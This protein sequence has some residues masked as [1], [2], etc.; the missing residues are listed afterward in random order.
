VSHQRD[1]AAPTA[2][3]PIR[4]VPVGIRRVALVLSLVRLVTPLAVIPFA[5]ALI[6]GDVPLLLL[7]RPARE[8]LLLGGGLSR[9]V[10]DPTVMALV[11]A[12]LP[13][14]TLGVWVFYIV[15]RAYGPQL[16]AG[17]GP[18]WLQR[19]IPQERLIQ[20]SRVLTRRG[21]A[22]AVVSR[23]AGFPPTLLAAAA[24]ASDVD[25]RRYLVADLFGMVLTFTTVVGIGFALGRAYERGGTWLTA[26]GIGLVVVLAITVSRWVQ[27][28][29][30]RPDL[31]ADPD[32]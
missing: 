3:D 20:S 25:S 7:L 23:L 2:D 1:V 18:A 32:A 13:L 16:R 12:Y 11:L 10:G 31:P 17:T 26:A 21:P 15:G 29:A 24:G 5:A 30:S 14:M 4:R 22:I 27:R 6:P 28:E 8:V 9:T 19:A